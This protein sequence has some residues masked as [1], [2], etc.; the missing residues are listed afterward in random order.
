MSPGF[1]RAHLHFIRLGVLSSEEKCAVEATSTLAM[2]GSPVHS[3]SIGILIPHSDQEENKYP[4]AN[5]INQ[6]ID[7]ISRKLLS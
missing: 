7:F 1:L 3:F 6:T 2:L 5:V 4:H